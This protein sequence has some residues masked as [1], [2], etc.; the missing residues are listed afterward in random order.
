M[1]SSSISFRSSR[2][3]SR[4]K[5]SDT[6]TAWLRFDAA[7]TYTDSE[8]QNKD[9]E[10]WTRK[11]YLPQNKVTGLLTMT[12]PY[13]VTA[14]FCALWQDEKIVP[15]YDPQ[16][17]RVRWEEPSVVTFDAALSYTFL[18]KYQAS[19]RVENLLDVDYTEGAYIAP[20]RSIFG[21]IKLT[22]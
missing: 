2:T 13:D 20:G 17:N 7:Y 10:Q 5:V 18:K 11:E 14:S 3:T 21:G 19:V 12:L 15:L 16:F 8:Y 22:F 4:R 1:P 9:A 6:S